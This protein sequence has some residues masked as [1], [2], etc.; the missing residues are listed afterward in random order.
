M[1]PRGR[2]DDTDDEGGSSADAEGYENARD[3][4]EGGQGAR[5]RSR[6]RRDLV[7]RNE[8]GRHM[9]VMNWWWN[10]R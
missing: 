1:L 2:L 4:T 10:R 3:G 8:R 5:N 9:L 6:A 7:V